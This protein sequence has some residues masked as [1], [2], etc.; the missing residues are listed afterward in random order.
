MVGRMKGRVEEGCVKVRRREWNGG[1]GC[2]R[3]SGTVLT[4][5]QGL[6][7]SGNGEAVSIVTSLP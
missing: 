1:G 6:A 4:R 5:H 7:N 3:L 2:A